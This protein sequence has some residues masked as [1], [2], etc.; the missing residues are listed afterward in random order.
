MLRNNVRV[1]HNDPLE[2]DSD[3][4]YRLTPKTEGRNDDC[5]DSSGLLN[6]ACMHRLQRHD[7][8]PNLALA[9]SLF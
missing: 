3:V 2:T 5:S 4:G 9:S 1:S 6:A 7:P 8:W